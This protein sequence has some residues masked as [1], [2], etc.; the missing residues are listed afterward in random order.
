MPNIADVMLNKRL[1]EMAS[2]ERTLWHRASY[3]T[4]TTDWFA[5]LEARRDHLRSICLRGLA[6]CYPARTPEQLDDMLMVALWVN[7]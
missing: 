3:D 4:E 1:D 7:R 2:I 6:R 5:R